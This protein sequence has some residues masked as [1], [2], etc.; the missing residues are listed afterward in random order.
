MT[1]DGGKTT[2]RRPRAFTARSST[3]SKSTTSSRFTSY[4]SMQDTGSHR[5]A[6]DL[7]QGRD[8]LQ[9]LAV[10]ERARA[11]EGSNQ[12]IDP[13]DPNI[14]YSHGYLRQ[15]HAHGPDAAPPAGRPAAAARGSASGRAAGRDRISGR[16]IAAGRAADCAPSG[17]RRSS[18][19]RS[20]T[21]RSTRATSTCI[22]RTI[23][24][25]PGSGSARDLTDNNPAQMGVN[26]FAIPYQTI[27]QI[28]ESPREGGPPLR[29]H[30]RRPRARDD[31]RRQDVDGVDE[32][33]AAWPRASGSRA[34]WR[35]STTTRP[36]TS[37]SAGA[38]TTTSRRT[39]G[40][41]QT[42]ASPWKSIVGNIPAG[43]INV[44]R[45]DPAV[46]SLLYAGNDF[47]VY[48]STN[49]GQKWNVLGAN[50]PTVEVSDLQI[51]PRD[52]VIVIST[53]GRGMWVMDA[54]KVRA[55]K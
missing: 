53:Y 54:L 25:T 7:S 15:L 13:T 8:N 39:C 50:L 18:C 31:G 29:R 3:T 38:K 46:T 11:A 30:G 21:T 19:R 36:C 27:T 12:A 41:P 28:A 17:W 37:R 33:P 5:V 20:I 32:E 4:G 55:I 22:A 1:E 6:L 49:G 44:I 51:Q 34:S 16:K 14:V 35:R 42:T 47:G 43:S 52:N 45:E 40:S 2:K 9:P 23:A 26:P 48:V 10:A 24:A